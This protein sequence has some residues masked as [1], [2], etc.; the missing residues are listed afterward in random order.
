MPLNILSASSRSFPALMIVASDSMRGDIENV[1]SVFFDLLV[2]CSFIVVVGVVVEGIEHLLSTG[3]P[4]VD[5]ESGVFNATP[6]IEWHKKLERLGWLLVIVGV[7]GEGIFEVYT[8]SADSILQEFNNTLLAMATAQAGNAAKS[9]K[10][11]RDEADAATISAREARKQSDAAAATAGKALASAATAQRRIGE[12]NGQLVAT[13]KQ[14]DAVDA[15]RAEMQRSMT[16]MAI[17]TAP[18]VF[19]G[20]S[21]GEKSFADPLK[22]F[23]RHAIV[24]FIVD[25]EAY[26]AARHLAGAFKAAGWSV[27]LAAL[28]AKDWSNTPDGIEI[29][30]YYP[31]ELI[32]REDHYDVNKIMSAMQDSWASDAVVDAVVDF[33]HSYHWEARRR[34]LLPPKSI[35]R[36]SIEITVGLYPA[37]TL[38]VPPGEEEFALGAAKEMEE[39][40]KSKEQLDKQ[41][42]EN[43]EKRFTPEQFAQYQ[44]AQQ[45]QEKE[46]KEWEE[47]EY[48][49]CHSL[50][51]LNGFSR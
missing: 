8:S 42:E 20:W 28:Q 16:D 12:L 39:G 31:T 14:L 50:S 48:G 45:N 23:S 18:R 47:R 11:A 15:Q 35:S 4:Y 33:L 24:E 43:I 37:H 41:M 27:E 40:R 46:E 49:P 3:K 25:P 9:A 17:C 51:L 26:R 38:V 21:V 6:L 22:P 44:A 32:S 30:P 2:V 7:L 10:T 13:K 29:H 1:R 36:D 5:E 34:P 19:D